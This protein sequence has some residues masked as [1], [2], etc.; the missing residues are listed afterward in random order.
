MFHPF[1][2]ALTELERRDVPAQ[3]VVSLTSAEAGNAGN[4]M[5]TIGGGLYFNPAL[6]LLAD[7]LLVTA[8][9]PGEAV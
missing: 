4:T 1:R 5:A 2:P 9:S 6:P 8:G 7:G 3:W